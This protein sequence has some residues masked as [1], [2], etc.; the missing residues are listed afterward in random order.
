[1]L[2]HLELVHASDCDAATRRDAAAIITRQ[3]PERGGD[4]RAFERPEGDGR[5][6]GNRRVAGLALRRRSDGACV[7][8]A[9][10]VDSCEVRGCEGATNATLNSLVVRESARGRGVGGRLCRD[11]RMWTHETFGA[12]VVT[13]WCEK[14]LVGFYERCGFELERARGRDWGEACLRSF[15]S[16]DVA[17]RWREWNGTLKL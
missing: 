3:W 8:C 6:M 5:S 17:R 15:G 11:A 2:D 13:V 4:A 16:D 9:L 12:D 7:G 14:E 1:M 10:V